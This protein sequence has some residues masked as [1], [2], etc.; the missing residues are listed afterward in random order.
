VREDGY[1][2]NSARY[3]AMAFAGPEAMAAAREQVTAAMNRT[4]G[5]KS[6]TTNEGWI[7]G[8]LFGNGEVNT[9]GPYTSP[10][11]VSRIEKARR[12]IEEHRREWRVR[13]QSEALTRHEIETDILEIRRWANSLNGRQ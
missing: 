5:I 1:D 7:V 9:E 6:Y 10:A 4:F 2:H 3:R 13:T 8:G 11:W 12:E